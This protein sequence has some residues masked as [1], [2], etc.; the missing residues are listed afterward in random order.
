LEACTYYNPLK[1]FV[2]LAMMC[3]VL[4]ALSLIGG[5]ILQVVS[6][7]VL[8]VGAILLAIP[9]RCNGAPRGASEA[10]H[11]SATMMSLGSRTQCA[12]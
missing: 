6:G 10:D 4:A 7:F 11:E 9:R 2:L 12:E 8:G 5:L 1:I 3:M